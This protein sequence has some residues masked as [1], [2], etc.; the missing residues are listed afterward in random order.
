MGQ[1]E[2]NN[3]LRRYR[4]KWFNSN[5]LTDVLGIS[6]AS[7]NICLQRMRK[8]NEVNEK[9]IR[10]MFKGKLG[11]LISKEVPFYSYKRF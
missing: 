11:C 7:I 10:V 3:F 2:V 1:D 8:H 4:N 9:M 6:R 5:E